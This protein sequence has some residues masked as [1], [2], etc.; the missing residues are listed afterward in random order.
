MA[1]RDDGAEGADGENRRALPPPPGE[2]E[3]VITHVFD[4]PR[5][6]VWKA[7][8]ES[9][10]LARW[11]GPEDSTIEVR[12][13]DLRPVG[14]FLYSTRS[15]DGR[16]LWG[17]FVYRDIPPPE[18]MVFVTSFADEQGATV[19][20][21]F[22]PTWPLKVLNT[23]TLTETEGKTTVILRGGPINAT[24]EERETFWRA[25]QVLRRGFAGTFAR[26]VAYLSED[27]KWTS[28]E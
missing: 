21:P 6:L 13:L 12:T 3:L 17:K 20:A 1:T 19:R 28:P 4:A 14:V 9:A 7:F 26:L 11:W 25:Q 8:A 22:S 5:E 27:R 18:R 16:V 10:R 15:L 24:T 2:R 23:L